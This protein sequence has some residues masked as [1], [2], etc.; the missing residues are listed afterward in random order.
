MHTVVRERKYCEL[1]VA[2]RPC[3]AGHL[4]M[5]LVRAIRTHPSFILARVLVNGL[6]MIRLSML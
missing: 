4:Y 6:P 2:N 5:T 3:D 1:Y